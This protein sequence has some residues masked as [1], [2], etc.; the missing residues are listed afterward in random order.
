MVRFFGSK[1]EV[2]NG[3]T[4]NKSKKKTG[5]KK[6]RKKNHC[7]YFIVLS[8]DTFLN[9]VITSWGGVF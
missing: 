9:D 7:Y 8:K 4:R 5:A 3:K 6:D 2:V 1:N